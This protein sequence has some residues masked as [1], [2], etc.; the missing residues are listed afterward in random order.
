MALLSPQFYGLLTGREMVD[1]N[2]SIRL[3]MAIGASLMAGWTVLLLWA[4]QKPIERRGI[5]LITVVPALTGL[6]TV[7]LIGII[8]GHTGSIWI[9]GKICFLAIIMLYGYYMATM[10]AR[11]NDH[12]NQ[13]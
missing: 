10:V 13:H 7:T 8:N 4:A 2:L 6:I 9:L 12:E 11:E 5:L 3:I 1:A